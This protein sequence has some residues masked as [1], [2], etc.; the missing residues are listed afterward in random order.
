M[1]RRGRGAAGLALLLALSACAGRELPREELPEASLVVLYRDP[2][3]A[4]KRAD[5][6]SKPDERRN[7]PGMARFDDLQ[8]LTGKDPREIFADVAGRL[9]SVDPRTGLTTPLST[10]GRG[11]DRPRFSPD[12][13][14][15]AFVTAGDT[16]FEL[17]VIDVATGNARRFATTTGLQG[18]GAPGPGRRLAYVATERGASGAIALR[19]FVTGPDLASP[20]AITPGPLDRSPVWSPDG[21]LVAFE[22]RDAGGADAIGVVSPDG[23]GAV[24]LLARGREPSFSPDG[25]WVVYSTRLGSYWRLWRVRPDGTG[26]LPLGEASSAEADER[27]PV[28]SPDGRFV[29]YVSDKDHHQTLRVRRFDGGGDRE[30]L[31]TGDGTAPAW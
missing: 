23:T 4:R 3:T 18:E 13:S 20:R 19:I 12:R 11:A 29:A 25:Q 24:R 26:K 27:M 30:L 22:T 2:E 16:S 10:A 17:H 8:R 14:Q 5:L 28:V 31:E 6:L 15:L 7:R 9:V 21:S 1:C